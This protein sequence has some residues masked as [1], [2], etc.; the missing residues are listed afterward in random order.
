MRLPADT[1]DSDGP[2]LTPVI[3]IVFLLLI[4]FLVATTYEQEERSTDVNLP[5]IT[6]AQPESSSGDLVININDSGTYTVLRKTYTEPELF[7]VIKEFHTNNQN[8]LALIRGDG[9]S[10][11][12]YAVR[13]MG[14]CNTVEMKYKIAALQT[15]SIEGNLVVPGE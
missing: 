15:P 2:N 14:L 10:A 13:V 11:L 1:S 7:V 9:D 3:D 12:K 6:K 4:F 8:K 5:E